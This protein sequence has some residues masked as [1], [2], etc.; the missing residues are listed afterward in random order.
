MTGKWGTRA[1]V[2]NIGYPRL[3][4]RTFF[5]TDAAANLYPTLEDK[6]GIVQNAIELSHARGIPQ[7][8]VA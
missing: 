7:P 5:I 2:E 8:R 6:R 4:F 3:L 1:H